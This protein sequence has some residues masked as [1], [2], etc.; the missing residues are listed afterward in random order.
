MTRGGSEQA[1]GP[2]VCVPARVERQLPG[3]RSR[4]SGEA[5][6]L[7]RG[8]DRGADRAHEFI[9]ETYLQHNPNVAS[10]RDA[11]VAYIKKTRPERPIESKITFPVV[12]IL[13]EG[14][15]VMLA[16]VSYKDDPAKPG[17]QYATT[18]FDL[19]RIENG[20]IAEHWDSVEKSAAALT[21][22]PN[23][24]IKK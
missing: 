4:F 3:E 22:D 17:Q 2:P 19:F 5:S 12:S 16:T 18:H 9:A 23:T 20:K 1:S 21:Y 7:P 15:Y 24:Q 13:A 6:A 14:D 8:I 11:F 10:G